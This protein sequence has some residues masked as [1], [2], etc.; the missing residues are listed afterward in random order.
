MARVA[1]QLTNFTGGELSPR[2]DGRNDLTKYSSGCTRLENFIIY[3][4]GAAARRSGTNFAAEVANSANKTRLMPFEFSTTQTYMLEFSNLKIRVYKDSSTVFEANKAITTITKANPAVVTANGHGYSDGDEVKIRN[5][6]GMTEVNEKRFLVA[7]KTTNTFELTNKDG[8][9]INSTSFTTYISGGIVNKVFEITTPYTTTQLFD[10][11]FVQSADVMYLCHPAHPPATLSRTGDISWTLADVVFTK[12]PFQDANI[13]DTTLTPSSASTGSRT[14][15][16]SAITG[17]NGGSGFLSTD[18]GRFIYFNDGYGKI[19]AVGSTTSITVDVTIAYANGNAITAW[20]LGSFSNTTGFPTCVTFFEQR[21]VFAGTTNQPQTVFFSKSGDYENMDAN[22]GGT[23]A[24]SDAIIYTIAS[25]QVNAIRFMTATRTLVIGTAGGEFSVSGGGT[26]SAITP[27]NI[28][29]KKQSNHGASNLDAI[30]VGNVTLFLQRA[31][32]KVRELAYNFDVDGYLAPDMTILSEHITEG[33]L[34]QIAYQQEPNQIIW[35]VRADGELIGLTYQREQE[36]TAW[37]RHIFGGITGIPT[38]TVT[39]YANIIIGT[40]IVITKSDGTQI[41]FTSTTGTASAQQFKTETNNNT[42]ATNLKNS[43]NAA[44]NTSNTGVTAVVSNNIITLTEAVPTGLGY[45]SMKTFDETRLKVVS[46]TKAECESVAVIPTDNDEYQ[47]WFIIKRTIDGVTKRYV[48]FL[49]TF[50]FTASD[51][52]TFNFLDSAASYNGTAATTISGLDYLE[53]Q[54]VHILSNGATHPTRVVVNGVVTLEKAS[55]NVKVGLGYSSILQTMR[56][57]AGSQNGTSQAKTKRIY[58]ITLR[59]FESI[60]VEVGGSLTDMERIP[61][62]KSSNVMDQGIPTFSGDKTVEFR[63][64]YNT[65]GFIFVRQ[66]Q[67]LPLTVLSL[68]P[69]LQTND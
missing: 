40:R 2:L 49:N 65:D 26:D 43:I 48:E 3:P 50:N 28:L 19:T 15:T 18:V 25:N 45:L 27:T 17:I 47:T 23:V 66:T 33:G 5:V 46:Q 68:Y 9:D 35:S 11:K 36:V 30:S 42:T 63:G 21:L 51:N 24:D 8:T 64:D 22:I 6:I 62:R 69:D 59:L 16:A 20:Q 58:E 67:P 38:I 37:H 1:V 31:R 57:D 52:T 60:G 4:H 29:I 13:T 55:T 32:R 7:N 10:I 44:N 53:G 34:T 41:T 39:D 56:I 61:F 12:G 14:I 54:T